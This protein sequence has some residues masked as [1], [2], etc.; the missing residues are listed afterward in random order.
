[1][2]KYGGLII[3]F[4]SVFLI[5]ASGVSASVNIE[6]DFSKISNNYWNL[7]NTYTIV[8]N[9][10]GGYTDCFVTHKQ[11][12]SYH[13]LG[14]YCVNP[15][16]TLEFDEDNSQFIIQNPVGNDVWYHW[17]SYD[18][19]TDTFVSD[20]QSFQSGTSSNGNL[21]FASN[22]FGELYYTNF[23]INYKDS[24]NSFFGPPTEI[25][26]MFPGISEAILKPVVSLV[27]GLI[28]LVIG[29]VVFC[30]ALRKGLQ[31]LLKTLRQA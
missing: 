26:K 16:D 31:M 23:T 25:P 22:A 7:S 19:N 11:N 29:L 1:M 20:F 17:W 6:V 18:S 30:L 10:S 5:G 9:P 24:N 3:A 2:K 27:I 8:D 15:N 4:V 13:Y 12:Y 21:T 28:P 14:I